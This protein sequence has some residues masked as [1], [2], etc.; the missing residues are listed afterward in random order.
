MNIQI[1]FKEKCRDFWSLNNTLKNEIKDKP[2]IKITKG[3]ERFNIKE[4]CFQCY[5]FDTTMEIEPEDIKEKNISLIF[6]TKKIEIKDNDVCSIFSFVKDDE[7]KLSID[8]EQY[9]EYFYINSSK[10]ISQNETDTVIPINVLSQD[11]WSTNVFIFDYENKQIRYYINS[12]LVYMIN[13]ETLVDMR[14]SSLY[15]NRDLS[16]NGSIRNIGVY[17]C[18]FSYDDIKKL[19]YHNYYK[20]LTTSLWIKFIEFLFKNRKEMIPW[21]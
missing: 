12:V 13:I 14:M 6:Q 11:N 20:K 1:P 7:V 10:K 5:N 19:S 15:F 8:L 4:K 3:E 9:G 2:I 16:C 17:N 18:T 21:I